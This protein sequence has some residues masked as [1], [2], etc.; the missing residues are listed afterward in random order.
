MPVFVRRC[1][2][3]ARTS[4]VEGF[5]AV[6]P[7][8]ADPYDTDAEGSVVFWILVSFFGRGQEIT[9]DVRSYCLIWGSAILFC[10]KRKVPLWIL[11]RPGWSVK[12]QNLR[13]LNTN[14][15]AFQRS[16]K[17]VLVPLLLSKAVSVS[18]PLICLRTVQIWGVVRQASLQTEPTGLTWALLSRV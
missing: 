16:F 15:K 11:L 8:V 5:S 14:I 12:C 1:G 9:L 2:R 4:L 18:P 10:S 13:G 3:W 17:T 6:C 7:A